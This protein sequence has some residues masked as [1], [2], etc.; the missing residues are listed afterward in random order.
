MCA[1]HSKYSMLEGNRLHVGLASQIGAT[2]F[3]L[4]LTTLSALKYQLDFIFI[5]VSASFAKVLL[6][7]LISSYSASIICNTILNCMVSL[8]SL[9]K[10]WKEIILFFNISPCIY[11][12]GAD[13]SRLD[14]VALTSLS[15]I[16]IHS[17]GVV[18]ILL[19]P[20]L[21]YPCLL[22]VYL[23]LAPSYAVNF[24][25]LLLFTLLMLDE[26]SFREWFTAFC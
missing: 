17:C 15:A 23:S 14:W 21:S 13:D 24:N 7:F 26:F 10:W 20:I 18:T 2:I 4:I 16:Y 6:E 8:L 9:T 25:V 3:L 5:W 22:Q 1:C 11:I 12:K 19:P